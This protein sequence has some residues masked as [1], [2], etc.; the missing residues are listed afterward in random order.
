[1][2]EPLESRLHR[3]L[4]DGDAA[5][6]AR[7]RRGEDVVEL[8]RERA[9][10]VDSLIRTAWRHTCRDPADMALVAVGGYGRGELHPCSDVDIL[11]LATAAAQNRHREALQ[12]FLAL[13]WDIGLHVGHSVRTVSACATSARND[14]TVATSLMESRLLGGSTTLFRSMRA[15]TAPDR[16]WPSEDFFKAKSR[17]QRA[18][19]AKY[20]DTAYKLEPNV[21]EGPGGL[22]D[23][24][25]IVWV[26]RR[27]FGTRT[28]HGLVDHGF[29]TEDEYGRLAKGRA[30]LWRV[31]FALHLVAGRR[32]DRLLFDYQLR[33]ARLFGYR[34]NEHLLGVERFMQ[35][36]YRILMSLGRLNEMLLQLLVEALLYDPNA[37]PQALDDDFNV[38]HRF[39]QVRTDDIF[40]CRPQTLMKLFLVLEQ[41]PELNGVSATTIRLIR[42]DLDLIDARF[43]A[44]PAVRAYFMAILR[45]PRGLSHELR[46]MN[47]YG[48]LGRYLPAFGEI[49]GRMQYDLFHAYT[50]DEHILFVVANLRSFALERHNHEFPLCSRIMQT[51]AKPEVAYLA[52][53]FHD[54]A[55]GRGGDHSRLG[56]IDAEAFCL[57]HD[58]P[59]YDARLVAWLVTHHLALSLTAQKKDINDPAVINEFAG[60]VGDQIHLDLLYM[61][62]V[63]DVRATNPSLWN[64][65]KASLFGELYAN[66]QRALRRGLENPIDKDELIA[67]TQS[68]TR[69]LLQD[70]L[71]AG[72]IETIWRGLTEN[73]FLQHTPD[74]IAW[75]TETLA[76]RK[77]AGAVAIML[78]A[79]SGRGGTAISI[80][81][82]SGG[83]TFGQATAALDQLGL[84]IVDAR[85]VPLKA[86]ASF[87]TYVVLEDTG[88]PIKES[89]RL[90]DIA[91]L[92]GREIDRSGV[93]PMAV[94]R[95]VPRQ[96]R[97]FSTP[98]TVTFTADE[99]NYRTVMEITAGDRPGLLSEIG[100]VLQQRWIHLQ[101]AKVTTVGERAEDVFFINAG[102]R[103]LDKAAEQALRLA[104]MKEVDV[105]RIDSPPTFSSAPR[106]QRGK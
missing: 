103:A 78:R 61:L 88:E 28:M 16:L 65:W 23:I 86:G 20:D 32:E 63:A 27:H 56:A 59:R 8:V 33:I 19:H 3:A 31:R 79:D 102:G 53:L 51:L 48:V 62:T 97:M 76:G 49:V 44:D 39:L 105:S 40:R 92:L 99:R 90:D 54:I 64:S 50:V 95:R 85:I 69:A 6:A 37:P 74:E 45:E 67:E 106:E 5:L 30:F 36:Y 91:A 1:V 35:D 13:L 60:L 29:L 10:L 72:R 46:R 24:Q 66:T 75:H 104:L 7:F 12:Q 68:R 96:V 11:V 34:D 87:D 4:A 84:T 2:K 93:K 70:R 58:M 82:R 83:P 25:V 98:T 38:R 14:I 22:R 71:D 55:K 26:A 41:H 80:H 100:R 89:H 17:E 15:T 9:E 47:H 94:T 21:K 42:R 73:Y 43:R 77:S 101:N 18:R 57:A 81:S 52:G